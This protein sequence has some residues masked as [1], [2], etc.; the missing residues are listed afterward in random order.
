M[1]SHRYR[2][3]GFKS[4]LLGLTTL[5]VVVAVGASVPAAAGATEADRSP[6][7]ST[8]SRTPATRIVEHATAN[9]TS[10]LAAP[11][12]GTQI[13][14]TAA[15]DFPSASS[16]VVG[17]VGF[18]DED[19]VGYFWSASR[20]DSVSQTIPGPP[21]ISKATLDVEV[22]QNNLNG[23][24]QVNWD[25][26]INGDVVGNFVVNEGQLGPIHKAFTFPEKTGGSYA[27]SIKVTNDVAGGQGSHTLA[28]AGSFAHSIELESSDF[29]VYT[30][31]TAKYLKNMCTADFTD[32]AEFT[33]VTKVTM[34]GTG[35]T[36]HSPRF[37]E[38]AAAPAGAPLPLPLEVRQVPGSWPAWGSAP[39]VEIPNPRVLYTQ[40]ATS[41][42]MSFGKFG[43]R[44]GVNCKGGVE[45]APDLPESHDYQGDWLDVN[46]VVL[47]T[48]YVTASSPNGAR[49]LGAKVRGD[50]RIKMIRVTDIS[51]SVAPSGFAIATLHDCK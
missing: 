37:W 45:V 24:A 9:S 44:R 40:D 32:E 17:S 20:G 51:T 19:E 35:C 30:R 8:N 5:L 3:R 1:G 18:I 4:R 47:G 13:A 33:E 27:V 2:P 16:T 26:V 48:A 14:P 6:V 38:S 28:Y 7:G 34:P 29:I 11:P 23:G 31:P 46:G 49:L 15:V 22:V 39:F 41:V 50:P 43:S 36:K 42:T 10:A 25:V 12:T 21:A